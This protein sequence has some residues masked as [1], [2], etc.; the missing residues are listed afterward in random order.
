MF[1]SIFKTI[2]AVSIFVADRMS[3][4]TVGLELP[5][6]APS[7]GLKLENCGKGLPVSINLLE[8]RW[9]L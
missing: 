4:E 6:I 5:M 9:Q 8:P 3:A 2:D 7:D 1:P